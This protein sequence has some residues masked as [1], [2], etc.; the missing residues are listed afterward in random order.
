M[1]IWRQGTETPAVTET[2]L[3]VPGQG[4]WAGSWA[5]VQ[6]ARLHQRAMRRT[7]A[8]FRAASPGWWSAL[9]DEHML[10]RPLAAEAVA[11]RD[12]EALARVWTEQ[13]RYRDLRQREHDVRR[14]TE[15]AALFLSLLEAEEAKAGEG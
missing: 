10:K 9:F 7:W 3:T 5:G 6:R 13:F 4:R 8:A 2:V 14:V 15:V 1:A 12:A 11:A